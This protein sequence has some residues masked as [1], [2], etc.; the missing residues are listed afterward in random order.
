M[1][2]HVGCFC[3][4]LPDMENVIL[5]FGKDRSPREEKSKMPPFPS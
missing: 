1:S 3:G 2:R 5:P 4:F